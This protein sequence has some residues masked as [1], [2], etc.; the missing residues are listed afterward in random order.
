M[1]GG[2]PSQSSSNLRTARAMRARLCRGSMIS[3][4]GISPRTISTI[5][6]STTGQ[7]YGR[8]IVKE[9][10]LYDGV[11]ALIQLGLIRAA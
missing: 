6:A 7:A 5:C 11:T 9:I 4:D 3:A 10:G 1:L 8:S 2:S